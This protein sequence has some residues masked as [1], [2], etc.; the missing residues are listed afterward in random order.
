MIGAKGAIYT[1]GIDTAVKAYERIAQDLSGEPMAKGMKTSMLYVTADAK[2]LALVDTGRLRSSISPAVEIS[3]QRVLG[4]VGSNVK[5]APF[6]ELGTKPHYPPLAALEK[7][8]NR[9]GISAYLVQRG[10]GQH[11]TKA[12]PF[13]KPAFEAN[14]QRIF[15]LLGETVSRIVSARYK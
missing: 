7:W 5:Y 6:V 14:I 12:R 2:R 15:N 11:G 4:I 9:H 10:I 1:K 3:G 13:L 8:A